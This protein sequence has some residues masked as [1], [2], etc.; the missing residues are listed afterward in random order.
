MYV[1]TIPQLYVIGPMHP[2][3]NNFIRFNSERK[4]QQHFFFKIPSKTNFQFTIKTNRSSILGKPMLFFLGGKTF[5]ELA[6]SQPHR[7]RI[8]GQPQPAT[9]LQLGA[10]EIPRYFTTRVFLAPHPKRW[11]FVCCW[12]F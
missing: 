4:K 8:F 11:F 3:K 2:T 7:L 5:D 6:S 9:R 1:Y 12:D 10:V